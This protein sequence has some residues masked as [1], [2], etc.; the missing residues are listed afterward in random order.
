VL[1]MDLDGF[2]TINDSLVHDQA[3]C[4]ETDRCS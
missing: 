1:F 2:K 3:T 4:C